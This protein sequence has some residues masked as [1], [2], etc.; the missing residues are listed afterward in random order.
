MAIGEDEIHDF[1]ASRAIGFRLN[2]PRLEIVGT[3]VVPLVPLL[4]ADQRLPAAVGTHMQAVGEPGGDG[5]LLRETVVTPTHHQQPPHH[6][7][8][9][10]QYSTRHLSTFSATMTFKYQHNP[11]RQF[12]KRELFYTDDRTGRL[13][14]VGITII[15]LFSQ[16]QQFSYVFDGDDWDLGAKG[17]RK[18]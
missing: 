12:P 15:L 5:R 3:A 17:K 10:S 2:L 16:K 4:N 8:L 18:P 13:R 1:G 7:S 14:S 9:P 11:I 6:L